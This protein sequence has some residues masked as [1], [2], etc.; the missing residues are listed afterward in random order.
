LPGDFSKILRGGAV[1]SHNF[2]NET[3]THVL[4]N[5]F[6]CFLTAVWASASGGFDI[7]SDTH[8]VSSESESDA[9]ALMKVM[10]S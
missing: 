3:D 5:V 6:F 4:Q 10:I 8:N 1:F 7:V 9:A 2:G